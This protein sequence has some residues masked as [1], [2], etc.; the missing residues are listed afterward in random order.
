MLQNVYSPSDLLKFNGSDDPQVL[1]AFEGI[2]YDVTECPKWRSGLHEQQHFP[3]ID[4]TT[5]ILDAPH[6]I[7]VFNHPCVKVV[8][9]MSKK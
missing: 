5:S 1:I 3:G 9:I 4:L 2:V 6:S 7:E 8:G